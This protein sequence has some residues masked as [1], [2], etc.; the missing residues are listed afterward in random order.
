MWNNLLKHCGG[1]I[2]K[3]WKTLLPVLY[4]Y[5]DVQMDQ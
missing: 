2:L 5:D 4:M 3:D 1:S